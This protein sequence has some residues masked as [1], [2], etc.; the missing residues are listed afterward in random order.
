MGEEEDVRKIL[1]VHTISFSLS[2]SNRNR[3]FI[4]DLLF[5]AQF[6]RD[7]WDIWGML[8]FALGKEKINNLLA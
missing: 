7:V 3:I 2:I 1:M 8:A 6:L 4:S 5:P